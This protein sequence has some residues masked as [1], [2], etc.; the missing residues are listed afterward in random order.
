MSIEFTIEN[1]E[2][3]E[4]IYSLPSCF[5]VCERCEGEG[6]HLNSSIGEHAYTSEEFNEAFFEEEDKA[7]YF[8]HGGRYDVTC[9]VCK[10]KR[11]VPEVDEAACNSPEL[12]EILALY[13]KKL[14]RQAEYDREDEYERRMGC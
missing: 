12:K 3:E 10:G 6:T 14:E 13:Y 7:E 5:E 9:E 8:R 11:V 2:G 4:V 1:D